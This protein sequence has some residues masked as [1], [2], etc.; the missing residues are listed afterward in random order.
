MN[1]KGR[2]MKKLKYSILAAAFC[3]LPVTLTYANV[4]TSAIT[5]QVKQAA[6]N[7]NT[8]DV[9]QLSKLPGIGKKKAQAIIDYREAKGNF[10]SLED[11]K[12]VKGIGKKLAAK[13]E[14]KISF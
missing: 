5:Q 7:I 3:M 9:S 4:D 12:M 2:K 10:T 14:G 13:L 8:A 1:K 11:L 6:L